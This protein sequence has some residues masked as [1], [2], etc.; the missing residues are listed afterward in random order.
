MQVLDVSKNFKKPTNFNTVLLD[1]GP[2]IVARRLW[3]GNAN[4]DAVSPLI[5]DVSKAPENFRWV[6]FTNSTLFEEHCKTMNFKNYLTIN[7]AGQNCDIRVISH[8]LSLFTP[9]MLFIS[10]SEKPLYSS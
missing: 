8:C 9:T 2:E 7:P 5:S 6:V 3:N 1:L 4:K 10:K